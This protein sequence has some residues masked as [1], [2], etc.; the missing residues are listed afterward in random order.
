MTVRD[1]LRM[2]HPALR[3]AALDIPPP[4]FGTAEIDRL[5]QDL[6]DTMRA[7]QGLGLAAPQI[8]EPRRICALEIAH[9]P[10]YPSFEA[11]S[12]LVLVNPTVSALPDAGRI[13]CWEGCLSVPG[14]RGKVCRAKAVRVS[15]LDTSGNSLELTLHDAHAVVMQHELD[16]L[17][18]KLFVERADRRTLA[19]QAE[20]D[21]FVVPVA[22][23]LEG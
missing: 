17:D 22:P 14:L 10:R 19:F 13:A 15:A 8:A 12:L 16:H 23:L 1:L 5:A 11:L 18:G 3:G 7:H 20:Y 2:G 6:V 9:N 4:W 21:E